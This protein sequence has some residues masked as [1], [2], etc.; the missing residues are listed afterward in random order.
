MGCRLPV[1]KKL[2]ARGLRGLELEGRLEGKRAAMGAY[3]AVGR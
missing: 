3:S 1:P 2:E